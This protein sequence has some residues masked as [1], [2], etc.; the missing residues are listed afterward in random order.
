MRFLS[1]RE[2]FRLMGL[3]DC[4]IN[5]IQNIGISS[6]KQYKMAGNSIV[7][8]VLEGIFKE[9]LLNNK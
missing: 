5:K 4:E 6:S 2:Y 3:S 7:V 1:E 8:D 9:L